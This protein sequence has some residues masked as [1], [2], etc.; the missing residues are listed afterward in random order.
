MAFDN[1]NLK[2]IIQSWY[3]DQVF[4][5]TELN[6]MSNNLIKFFAIGSEILTETKRREGL[7]KLHNDRKAAENRCP[8]TPN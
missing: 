1:T 3:P 5:D 7:L 6:E 2:A 8:K 4:T